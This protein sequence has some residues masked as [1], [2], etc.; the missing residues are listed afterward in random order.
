LVNAVGLCGQI[1]ASQFPPRPDD[2][3]ELA[4]RLRT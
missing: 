4:N 2:S 3:D 1:L